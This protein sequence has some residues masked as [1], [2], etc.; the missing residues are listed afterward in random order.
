[1]NFLLSFRVV[2]FTM[3]I[4]FTVT[5]SK[6]FLILTDMAHFI[7]W[8]RPLFYTPRIYIKWELC[9]KRIYSRCAL[10]SISQASHTNGP[11]RS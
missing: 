9:Y 7:Q 3:R 4:L 10:E 8:G 5:A 2:T 11:E 1:M 6:I